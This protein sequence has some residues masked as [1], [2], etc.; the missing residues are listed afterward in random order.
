MQD[1]FET[2]EPIHDDLATYLLELFAQQRYQ[3]HGMFT[4]PEK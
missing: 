2:L 1:R 4:N 3:T